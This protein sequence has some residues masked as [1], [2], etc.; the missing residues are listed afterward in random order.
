MLIGAAII[1]AS[2]YTGGAAGAAA[3]AAGGA[4]GGAAA[5]VSFFINRGQHRR[6]PGVVWCKSDALQAA[7]N[8]R[9]TTESVP[10]NRPSFLFNGAVN[11]SRQ[12]NPVPLCYGQ[13]VVGSG[14]QFGAI[15]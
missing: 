13:M 3:G 9:G 12:G 15:S 6:I 7:I 5:G 8:Q 2:I 14:N 11:T 1:V 4:A 10:E